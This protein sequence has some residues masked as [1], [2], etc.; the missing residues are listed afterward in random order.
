MGDVDIPPSQ[1]LF[2]IAH[3]NNY[4]NNNYDNNYNNNYN[5]YSNNNNAASANDDTTSAVCVFVNCALLVSDSDQPTIT[6]QGRGTMITISMALSLALCKVGNHSIVHS[7]RATHPLDHRP[8]MPFRSPP[9]QHPLSITTL[10]TPPL[11]VLLLLPLDVFAG[12]LS[13]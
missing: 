5:N 6:G 10:T 11:N 7:L 2:Y 3:N 12:L 13:G 9:L 1:A 8:Y 4:N